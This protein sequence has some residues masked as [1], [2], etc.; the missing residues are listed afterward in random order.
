MGMLTEMRT[1]AISTTEIYCDQAQNIFNNLKVQGKIGKEEVESLH[2]YM[3]S[4]CTSVE[5]LSHKVTRKT[6]ALFREMVNTV[7]HY[8]SK[9]DMEIDGDE[10]DHILAPDMWAKIRASLTEEKKEPFMLFWAKGSTWTDIDAQILAEVRKGTSTWHRDRSERARKAFLVLGASGVAAAVEKSTL[11]YMVFECEEDRGNEIMTTCTGVKEYKQGGSVVSGGTLSLDRLHLPYLLSPTI[12][13]TWRNLTNV[14]S[15]VDETTVMA[16]I[17][18]HLE[19]AEGIWL[20]K[21]DSFGAQ[22]TDEVQQNRYS[23]TTKAELTPIPSGVEWINMGQAML[24]GNEIFSDEFGEAIATAVQQGTALPPTLLRTL[25]I[26]PITATSFIMKD[27]HSF[28]PIPATREKFPAHLAHLGKL[29]GLGDISA[30]A[31]LRLLGALRRDKKVGYVSINQ[32]W[33]IYV[34]HRIIQDLGR[35]SLPYEILTTPG[36]PISILPALKTNCKDYLRTLIGE[37]GLWIRG[38]LPTLEETSPRIAHSMSSMNDMVGEILIELRQSQEVVPLDL[39]THTLFLPKG[40]FGTLLGTWPCEEP[41]GTK[42]RHS[43]FPPPTPEVAKEIWEQLYLAASEKGFILIPV[44]GGLPGESKTDKLNRGLTSL[45]DPAIRE[46]TQAG[47][48]TLLKL[49]PEENLQLYGS[50]S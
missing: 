48:P 49:V 43:S 12:Y 24:E 27:G 31:M 16:A 15:V 2:F 47:W 1:Q 46:F 32:S 6:A 23:T 25:P 3:A 20:H 5:N 42:L 41:F 22:I 13:I 28:R 19:A 39:T 37:G 40:K 17:M 9:S 7:Q 34:A 30:T 36:Q 11:Q 44:I 4:A 26:P 10:A 8:L 21:Y 45:S 38:M 33:G 18:R 14:E 29:L 35:E 50:D